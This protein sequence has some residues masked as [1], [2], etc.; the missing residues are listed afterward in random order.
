MFRS[1][2]LILGLSCLA[3]GSLA[4]EQKL[5]PVSKPVEISVLEFASKGGLTPKQMEA[6]EDLLTNE[7]RGLGNFRKN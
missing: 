6:L 7:T 5:V 3:T 1:A 2:F 4:T